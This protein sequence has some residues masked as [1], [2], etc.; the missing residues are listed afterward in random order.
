M[1][2][3]NEI[4]MKIEG[5]KDNYEEVKVHQASLQQLSCKMELPDFMFNYET[6]PRDLCD[7]CWK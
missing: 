4:R 6:F 3:V 7:S 1:K 2:R 5:M